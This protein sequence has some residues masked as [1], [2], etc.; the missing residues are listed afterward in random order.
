MATLDQ[1]TV[2]LEVTFTKRQAAQPIL[3]RLMEAGLR[4]ATVLRGRVTAS[5]A[6][7]QL[8]LQGTVSAIDSAVQGHE[9]DALCFPRFSPMLA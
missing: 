6:W 8:E 3:N 5:D 9:G 2:V 1:K 7:F 4:S